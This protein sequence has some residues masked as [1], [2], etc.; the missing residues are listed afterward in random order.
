MSRKELGKEEGRVFNVPTAWR[1]FIMGRGE[2][3]WNLKRDLNLKKVFTLFLECVCMDV[4]SFLF[5]TL[6]FSVL[7][8][9]YK[10]S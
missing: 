10:Y 4:S 2:R 5:P 1:N 8:D 7:L 6:I 9:S 3:E